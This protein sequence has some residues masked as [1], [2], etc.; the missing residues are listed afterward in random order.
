[1]T[2]HNAHHLYCPYCHHGEII[3]SNR[4]EAMIS[5]LCSICNSYFYADLV[6][7]QTYRRQNY[8][9]DTDQ[10]PLFSYRV[11]CPCPD[12]RGEIRVTDYTEATVSVLCGK[13]RC[14]QHYIAD[15]ETMTATPSAAIRKPGR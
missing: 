9:R 10:K 12:C 4:A 14:H 7:L 1:M 6:T 3:V 13:R 15:L 2:E 11:H 8:N 5:A